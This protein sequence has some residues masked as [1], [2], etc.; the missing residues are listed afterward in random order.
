M[1]N[2]FVLVAGVNLPSDI[3]SARMRRDSKM[4]YVS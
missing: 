4:Y 3:R 2:R 1:S